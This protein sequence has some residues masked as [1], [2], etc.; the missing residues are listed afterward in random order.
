MLVRC[1]MRPI[2]AYPVGHG[3]AQVKCHASDARTL[4]DLSF[5]QN[6]YAGRRRL[7][8]GTITTHTHTRPHRRFLY[9]MYTSRK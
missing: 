9:D 8:I 3:D 5:K 1:A 6:I 7:Q 4:D 2:Q